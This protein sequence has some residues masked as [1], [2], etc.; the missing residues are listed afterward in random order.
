[1]ITM[2]VIDFYRLTD[3]RMNSMKTIEA[4]VSVLIQ[5]QYYRESMMKN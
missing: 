3:G 4:P 5:W 2:V 1:M